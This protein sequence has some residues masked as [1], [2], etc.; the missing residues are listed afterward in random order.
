MNK[1][2][3]AYKYLNVH[4]DGQEAPDFDDSVNHAEMMGSFTAMGFKRDEVEEILKCVAAV[5]NLGNIE[6]LDEHD[7]EASSVSEESSQGSG[8]KAKGKAKAKGKSLQPKEELS[9]EVVD[10]KKQ[11][12]PAEKKSATKSKAKTPAAKKAPAKSSKKEE[13]IIKA[14]NAA[15]KAKGIVIKKK[16][17]KSK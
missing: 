17:A 8:T 5:L 13:P 2:S 1:S 12:P 6:F 16:K 4:G 10:E 14:V 9:E 7:G 15:P 11:E 3:K